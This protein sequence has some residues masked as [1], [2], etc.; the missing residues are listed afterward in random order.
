MDISPAVTAPQK[1]DP[2]TAEWAAQVA[3]A[4]N[5]SANPPE[6]TDAVSTPN[7]KA[8]FV[9]GASFPNLGKHAR[10]M[11]FDCVLYAEDGGSTGIYIALPSDVAG[12]VWLGD[13]A[14][15][16]SRSQTLGDEDSAF[17][18]IAPAGTSPK[19]VY[20]G[21]EG[22]EE[23]DPEHEGK[24]KVTVTG[25][26][27]FAADSVG[28]REEWV[29][30]G[31]PLVLLATAKIPNGGDGNPPALRVGL[32]QY[33][34]GTILAPFLPVEGQTDEPEENV[35]ECGHP[36]NGDGT[37]NGTGNPLDLGNDGD[38]DDNPLDREGKGGY[39]PECKD[40]NPANDAA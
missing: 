39:T 20:L 17:V 16:P 26:R 38:G 33:H 32:V 18:R 8:T 6:R 34:R 5:A 23:P 9:P 4:A 37:G 28:A 2:I 40:D 3:S 31:T 30:K 7:G 36:M 10:I 11:A 15:P 19:F 27:V 1:G 12:W 13:K 25:W 21:F 29:A 24:T 35:P 22:R 14:V